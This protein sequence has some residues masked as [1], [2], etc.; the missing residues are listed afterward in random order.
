V[1]AIEEISVQGGV[2]S[3]QQPGNT[4]R[5]YQLKD[6]N[7]ETAHVCLKNLEEGILGEYLSRQQERDAKVKLYGYIP[8]LIFR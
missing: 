1:K 7:F 3:Y 8:P 5:L 6:F 2:A 4:G